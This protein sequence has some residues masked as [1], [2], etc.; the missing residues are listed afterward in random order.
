MNIGEVS[1][2]TGIVLFFIGVIGGGIDI[3]EVK[4]PEIT[5]APRYACFLG[6][7][8]FI[9]LGL[10]LKHEITIPTTNTPTDSNVTSPQVANT[11]ETKVPEVP[12]IVPTT[13]VQPALPVAPAITP[14]ENAQLAKQQALIKLDEANKRINVIWNAT[15]QEIRN[16]L[17]PEHKQWFKQ[18]EEDCSLKA[19]TE[20]TVDTVM[21]EAVKLNCM[22]AMTEPRIEKLQQEISELT[23][24]I[25]D[26]SETTA[27]NP[28]ETETLKNQA[29]A[30]LDE[31]NKR[32]KVVW[33]AATQ[34]IKNALLAEQ[35]Q[36]LKQR[37]E[38]C[39]LKASNEQPD[40]M[41]MQETFKLN[42]MA[43]IT[44]PRTEEL[45]QKIAGMTQ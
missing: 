40:D 7:V 4:I 6:S 45:K 34:E 38:D 41:V 26:E 19:S 27:S 29:Q 30:K 15:T 13:P 9:A 32:I 43:A 24:S 20:Q 12:A 18:R 31:A 2:Y 3:K 25:V 1:F 11:P 14:P 22:A 16:A 5:G 23:Q 8:L 42:C 39:S 44:D 21:Q 33:N 28:S 17:L 37:E 10:Y 35:T 36:W